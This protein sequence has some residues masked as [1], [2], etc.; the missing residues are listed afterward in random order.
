MASALGRREAVSF[1]R[2]KGGKG[3]RKWGRRDQ[4]PDGEK[5]N[6]LF[7]RRKKMVFPEAGERM[8][9]GETQKVSPLTFRKHPSFRSKKK[10]EVF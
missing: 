7:S 3:T 5:K 6:R 4:G 9:R 2:R 8:G 1:N 10:K